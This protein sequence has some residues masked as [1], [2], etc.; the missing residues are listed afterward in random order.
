MWAAI[1][2]TVVTGVDYV[3]SAVRKSPRISDV[4]RRVMRE[5]SARSVTLTPETA[6]L[7]R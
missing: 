4:P 1:V 3:R 6:H 7:R 5:P 2:L